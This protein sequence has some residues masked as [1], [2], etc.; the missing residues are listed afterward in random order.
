[1]EA[2][3][4]R[5]GVQLIKQ[6]PAKEQAELK[7][8][9][10]IPGSWFGGS[11]TPE[12]KRELYWAQANDS[13]EAHK[14]PRSGGRREQTCAAIHFLCESDVVDN[15]AHGGFWMPLLDW[16]RY[17]HDTYKDSRDAELPF[18]RTVAAAADAQSAAAPAA[19]DTKALIYS[20]YDLVEK[21]FHVQKSRRRREEGQVRVLP[22][23]ELVGQVQKPAAHLQGR[24]KQE[25]AAP[26]DRA[27][28]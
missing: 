10:Q 9:V 6:Y 17:R 12:E 25:L 18:I 13:S 20:E 1:M 4:A 3:A 24:P 19:A 15:A 21:G 22:L 11:L 16:N 5:L 23:Q 8:K 7:V 26:A 14:F 27:Q 2:A 28:A